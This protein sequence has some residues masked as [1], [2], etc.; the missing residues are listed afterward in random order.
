VRLGA[1][2]RALACV[3]LSMPDWWTIPRRRRERPITALREVPS[4]LAR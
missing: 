1:E 2:R 3:Q 4:A